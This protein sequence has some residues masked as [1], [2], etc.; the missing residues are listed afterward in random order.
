MCLRCIG[1]LGKNLENFCWGTNS[2]HFPHVQTSLSAEIGFPQGI[3]AYHTPQT[4]HYTRHTGTSHRETTLHKA[5]RHPH[6]FKPLSL[7]HYTQTHAYTHMHA[8]AHT[9]QPKH[10]QNSSVARVFSPHETKRL[11]R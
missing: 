2:N 5:Y 3:Q 9:R 4:L 8:Y 7:L 6:P 1:K 11:T 10:S